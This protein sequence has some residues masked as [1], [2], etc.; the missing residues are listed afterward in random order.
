MMKQ[1]RLPEEPYS[2]RV[3]LEKE[4]ELEKNRQKVAKGLEK[5]VKEVDPSGFI[6]SICLC[7]EGRR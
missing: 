7:W 5:A 6:L 1:K 2:H 3:A 4:R